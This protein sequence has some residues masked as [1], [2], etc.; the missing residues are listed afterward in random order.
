MNCSSRFRMADVIGRG[1]QQLRTAASHGYL[2]AWAANKGGNAGLDIDSRPL[3]DGF[4]DGP[5]EQ[6]S[7]EWGYLHG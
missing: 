4:F 6:T 3:R 2:M 7:K 1:G 5:W